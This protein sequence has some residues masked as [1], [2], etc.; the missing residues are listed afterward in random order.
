MK[1]LTVLS[2]VATCVLA[3]PA[4]AQ[5]ST[6]TGV[7]VAS[8]RSNSGAVAIGGGNATGGTGGNATGGNSTG[9]S[10]SS[11]LTL[12]SNVP[13]IQTV[14][15]VASGSQTIKNVPTVFAPGLAAAGLET[16]LGSVSAGVGV[17]GTGATFGTTIPDPGCA[18]RL[19]ARTLWSF[20]LKKAAIA[21]LCLTID[22]YNAMPDV[23]SIYLP[24]PPQARPV[25]FW[26]SVQ[27]ALHP[28]PQPVAETDRSPS[29]YGGD[30]APV[31]VIMQRN[32]EHRL[33]ADYDMSKHRC[34]VFAH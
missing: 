19:D 18:A 3:S 16:C 1:H 11:S 15:T 32:G 27:L 12:N 10:A 29:E 31:E 30:G 33:C 6:A 13:S 25:G 17:V 8:S 26:D 34:R 24:R 21:R 2:V 20:G 4:M 23:C 28:Q 9:G 14:N 5:S 22:I 7:G